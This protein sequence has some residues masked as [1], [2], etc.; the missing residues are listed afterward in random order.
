MP[1]AGIYAR[2]SLASEGS[3]SIDQQL[4]EGRAKAEKLGATVI[5][6]GIDNNVSASKT[7]PEDRPGWRA[8]VDALPEV[9]IVR[10]Q[11]RIARSGLDWARVVAWCQA[12]SIRLVTLD[13]DFDL[14][15]PTGRLVAGVLAQVAEHERD[16]IGQRVSQS[17]QALV[18][19]G[20]QAGGARP[21][22]LDKIPNPSGDGYVL[23]PNPE[24]AAVL[25]DIVGRVERGDSLR[26]VVRWLNAEGIPA[27]RGGQWT[28]T[29][30][31]ALL[32][33][34][35]LAGARVHRGRL[36]LDSSGSV[37]IDTDQAILPFDRWVRLRDGIEK[38]T[39]GYTPPNRDVL[40]WGLLRCGVCGKR[41]GYE[42]R[43]GSYKC[44]NTSGCDHPVGYREQLADAEYIEG[45]LDRFGTAQWELAADGPDVVEI[46]RLQAALADVRA[47][48]PDA[49]AEDMAALAQDRDRI[50]RELRRAQLS[51]ADSRPIESWEQSK[52]SGQTWGE[53]L[54]EA[55]REGQTR[56]VLDEAGVVA[57][58]KR[59]R[60]GGQKGVS[61]LIWDDD[62]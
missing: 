54:R 56:A 21:W 47:A 39:R 41:L 40:L 20:R 36:V 30:L 62:E 16:M 18:R 31:R 25:L 14:A 32:V 2:L 27:A 58:V 33:R 26:S 49:A 42:T 12:S 28:T 8:I 46:A 11:S 43:S 15:T 4:H 6:E 9:I 3:V 1:T 22:P 23:R 10:E 55:Q 38:R 51:V 29:A 52:G 57:T 24:R 17:R 13:G 35:A 60:R 61:R 7:R 44:R 48:L 50:E 59:S 19:Q 45:W 5:A 53:R 34:P 37:R